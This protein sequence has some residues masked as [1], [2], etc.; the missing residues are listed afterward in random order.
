[1]FFYLKPFIGFQCFLSKAIQEELYK[2]EQL[3]YMTVLQ[4]VRKQEIK[5][6]HDSPKSKGTRNKILAQVN[7]KDSGKR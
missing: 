6:C 5:F 7:T 3:D 1:M 2:V 4:K